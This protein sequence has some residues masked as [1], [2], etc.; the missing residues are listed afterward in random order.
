MNKKLFAFDLDGTLL[1]DSSNGKIHPKTMQMINRLKKEGH[2][3]CILTGRPWSATDK[4]YHGLKLDTI[5]ANYNGGHIHNPKD[6]SYLPT[7]KRIEP[8]I[9]MRIVKTKEMSKI[10]K[11]IAIETPGGLFL[12]T[13]EKSY[14]TETFLQGTEHKNV[15]SPINWTE[16]TQKPSGVLIEVKPAFAKD[17]DKIKSYFAAK[18]GD[19]VEFSYWDT[20]EGRNPILEFT[21]SKARKDIALIKIARYYNIEMKDVIAF[22]DGFNDVTMLKVAGVGVAMDNASDIVKTYANVVSKHSNKNGG[23]GKFIRWYLDK[24]HKKVD[25]TIYNFKT[26]KTTTVIEE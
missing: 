15:S 25:E 4:I 21:N 16:V 1:S 5:V 2:I 23:V 17:I 18:F 24:G 6:Y 20:G 10:A 9:A 11:N 13:E 14:F 12:K 8:S 26:L 22:G 19:L 7:V 3:I